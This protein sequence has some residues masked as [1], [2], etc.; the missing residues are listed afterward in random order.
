MLMLVVFQMSKGQLVLSGPLT[1]RQL[2]V[3]R[4]VAIGSPDKQIAAT[5][6]ISERAVRAHIAGCR[7]RLASK[8]RAHAVA[9]ALVRH[10]IDVTIPADVALR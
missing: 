6:S 8:S 1:E 7:S 3:L 9:V 5:L 2:E 10:L 4:L